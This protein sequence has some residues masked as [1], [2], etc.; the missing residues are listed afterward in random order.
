MT[1]KKARLAATLNDYEGAA[2]SRIHFIRA[3]AKPL[4]QGASP[5][6]T[7]LKASLL[8]LCEPGWREIS[9]RDV[10]MLM[11]SINGSCVTS[12]DSHLHAS[13]GVVLGMRAVTRAARRAELSA[14]LVAAHSHS[15]LLLQQLA[16]MADSH[17]AAVCALPCSSARLG[18]PFGLLRASAIG[19]R[20]DAF[21]TE[22]P[23]VAAASKHRTRFS[24][25]APLD[26]AAPHSSETLPD[27]DAGA[28]RD[29]LKSDLAA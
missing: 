22:H 8:A 24:E 1:K 3:D 19:L 7:K 6:K 10:S 23:L 13:R 16:C 27:I 11:Q 14:L 17:G 12:T 5:S 21:P 29:A 2:A 26:R 15:S 4:M 20:R 18:Q 28:R 25:E 9:P